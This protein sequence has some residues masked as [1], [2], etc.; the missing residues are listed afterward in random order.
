MAQAP[1]PSAPADRARR[2]MED[3]GKLADQRTGKAMEQAIVQYRQAAPLWHEL[4]DTA[5]EAKA[6]EQIGVLSLRLGNFQVALENLSAALPM[7]QSAGDKQEEQGALN[8]I[9]LVQSRLGNQRRAIEVEEQSLRLA[10]EIGNRNEE[11]VVLN[12][13]GLAYHELGEERQAIGEFEKALAIQHELVNVANEGAAWSNLGAIHYTQGDLEESLEAFER[14]LGLRKQGNDRRGEANTIGKIAVLRHAF[15]Q[16]EEALQLFQKAL[17]ID[18]EVGDRSEES[19]ATMNMGSVLMAL[20]RYPQAVETFDRAMRLQEQWG[21]TKDW[22]NQLS[23]KAVALTAMGQ[24]EAAQKALTDALAA[25]RSIENRR[26]ESESLAR[27]AALQ[28]A[29]G[30]P[31]E[32][33]QPATEAARIAAEIGEKRSRAE[34]LYRLAR[35]QK[36]LGR[37]REALAAIDAALGLSETVREGVPDYDLRAAFFSTVRDQYDLKVALQVAVG[38]VTGAFETAEASRARSL[39]DLLRNRLASGT[40]PETGKV[41]LVELARELDPK[42]VVL[43][44]SLGRESSYVFVVTSEGT[45]ELPLAGRAQI[46]AVA[47]KLYAA[48]SARQDSPADCEALSRMLLGRVRDDIRGKRVVVVPDGALAYIPFD[49]LLSSPGRRLIE[50]NEVVAVVSLSSLKLMRDR[51]RDRRPASKLVAVFADPVFSGNDP[52][53]RPDLKATSQAARG[54]ESG[55]DPR[56]RPDLKVTSQ[57]ARGAELSRSAGDAGLAGLERLVS[58]RREAAAIS[59]LAPEKQR[60]EALDFDARLA[61]V[62]D[63]KLA[64][65]RIV[66]FAT[67]GLMN[68]RD[69]RLSGLVFS[70]VDRQGR[71]Q[72]GFLRADEVANLK[73]G[74]DLVVLSACQTALGKELRGEGLLGLARGFMYAGAP[75]V[76]ASLWRVADSATTDLMSSFYQALLGSGVP[77]SEALRSAKLKLMRNPLRSAPYY[78]AGFSLEGDWR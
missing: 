1:E 37:E 23:A 10:Q 61:A 24:Y 34:A 58:S 29:R 72:N 13:L 9:G 21:K 5:Q 25:Q 38:D 43:E 50:D 11:A 73:L 18:R 52:R 35:C 78:W 3:A 59:A 16:D 67:H 12:N 33:V 53:V 22:G 40:A 19:T 17:E 71:P 56:V 55:N 77:A 62:Q 30:N 28:L 47:R 63:P 6:L 45:R 27:L 4:H 51:T 74:A 66:H 70:L 26:G 2:L 42:T 46:E 31:A 60:W 8:N 49:A 65:F 54:A 69:P 44:Y 41:S 75:R 48:W 14:A 57:A 68:S 15:G 36:A 7:F 39:Y 76:I 32:G 20:A 64:D